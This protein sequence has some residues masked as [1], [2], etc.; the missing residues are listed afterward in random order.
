MS[1]VYEKQLLPVFAKVKQEDLQTVLIYTR[2]SDKSVG[3]SSILLNHGVLSSQVALASIYFQEGSG[4]LTK[5]QDAV[6]EAFCS[7]ETPSVI[8]TGLYMSGMK[9]APNRPLLIHC[10][11]G[12]YYITMDMGGE[13]DVILLGVHVQLIIPKITS[14]PPLLTGVTIWGQKRPSLQI[15]TEELPLAPFAATLAMVAKRHL[16]S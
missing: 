2:T 7:F 11:D 15:V 8:E 9:C 13:R 3:K 5:F 4:K 14:L 16:L 1:E 6:R 10:K 12:K